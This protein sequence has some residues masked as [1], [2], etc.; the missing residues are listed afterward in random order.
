MIKRQNKKGQVGHAVTW[1]YKF[2]IL[3]LVI[4][5]I[6]AVI[7]TH[8]SQQYDI[9]NYEAN[10]I[11]RKIV[12]C[13]APEGK[14]EV[15]S[16]QTIRDCLPIDEKEIFLNITLGND[17]I[18]IGYEYLEILCQAEKETKVKVYPS[19][20]EEKYYVL[21]NGDDKKKELNIFLA[22]RKTEKNL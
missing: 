8:Y 18:A 16:E 9:R 3:V 15:F 10:T 5:G 2:F 17:Y 12:E 14:V 11:A 19:C 7:L 22:I 13:I 4:G 20:L 1:L 21:D 6:V